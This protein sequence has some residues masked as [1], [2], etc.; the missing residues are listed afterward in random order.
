MRFLT[1]IMNTTMKLLASACL[2]II[3]AVTLGLSFPMPAHAYIDAG[4]GSYIIQVII[5]TVL[6]GLFAIKI[7]WK[8]IILFAKKL[9]SKGDKNNAIK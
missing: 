8:K 5:A 9:F 3:I 7:F 4:T 2:L 6:G 1:F